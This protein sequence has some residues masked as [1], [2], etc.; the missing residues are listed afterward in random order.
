V[1]TPA[2]LLPRAAFLAALE[3]MLDLRAQA[4]EHTVEPAAPEAV[5]AADA[6]AGGE[7]RA[8]ILAAL[9]RRA[10]ELDAMTAQP[11]AAA[12]RR[13]LLRELDVA[14]LMSDEDVSAE[15]A[16]FPTLLGYHAAARALLAYLAGEARYEVLPGALPTGVLGAPVSLD[17]FRGRPAPEPEWTALGE[18]L[19]TTAAPVGGEGEFAAQSAGQWYEV[20]WRA[21]DGVTPALLELRRA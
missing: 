9:E 20:H 10:A 19:L 2:V 18:W 8:E 17:F 11:E 12:R 3:R 16:A 4:M 6:P 15:L 5:T 14:G 1:S 7:G 13:V 21:D